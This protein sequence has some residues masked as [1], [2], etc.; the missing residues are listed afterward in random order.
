MPTREIIKILKDSGNKVQI[1]TKNGSDAI[2]DFDLLDSGD[3]FGVTYAGYSPMDFEKAPNEEKG[4][5]TPHERLDALRTAHEQ[6]IRTWVSAEPVLNVTD[7][8]ELVGLADYI[9]LWKVGKLNYYPSDIDWAD[10]GK[11]AEN[12][13]KSRRKAYY[14]KDSLRAEMEKAK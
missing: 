5:G 9:D 1:L 12:L 8:L 10:F 7:V 2:R 11:R 4:S 13:L 3:W 6:G 14:I